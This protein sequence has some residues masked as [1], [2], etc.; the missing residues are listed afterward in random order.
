MFSE[1]YVSKRIS[2]LR[3]KKG[4]S[5]RDMS[6]SIGQCPSYIN[7]IENGHGLPSMSGFFYICEYF[8][9]SPQQFFDEGTENPQALAELINDLK[10]LTDEQIELL[11]G[12]VK[13]MK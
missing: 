13:Q 12:F 5:A 9:I 6:L 10:T 4:V 1:E 2:Q 7:N 11:K 3:V 8:K